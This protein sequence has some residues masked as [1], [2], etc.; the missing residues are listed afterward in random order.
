MSQAIPGTLLLDPKVIENPYPFYGELHRYAP[1]WQVPGAEVFAVS[2]HALLT[3]ATGRVE[4][5]S[6]NMHCFLYRNEQGLPS[7]LPLGDAGSRTLATADPP[8]HTAHKR[9]VFPE[10]VAKRM[11]LLEPEI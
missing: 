3:E 5:F 2:S 8:I 7:R 9:T 4:D 10:F 6:S 1:V 11:A